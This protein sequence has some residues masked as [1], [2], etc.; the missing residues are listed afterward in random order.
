MRIS[1]PCPHLVKLFGHHSV[2]SFSDTYRH[3]V[4]LSRKDRARRALFWAKIVGLVLVVTIGA[5]VRAEPEL[6]RVFMTAGMDAVAAFADL[7]QSGAEGSG[8]ARANSDVSFGQRDP[9]GLPTSRIKVNRL[10]S[11]A[12][13]EADTAAQNLGASLSEIKPE[14]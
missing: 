12:P 4:Y 2:M 5:T 10:G 11:T 14:G 6:R 3:E 7:N 13:I 8:S 9:A 1:A